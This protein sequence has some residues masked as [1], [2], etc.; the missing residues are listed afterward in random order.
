MARERIALRG[1]AAS[2]GVGVGRAVVITAERLH[3]R[4]S[5]IAAG[6]VNFEIERLRDAIERSRRELEDIRQ[7]LGDEAPADYRLILDA[8]MMM[9][10]DQLLVDMA[11]EAILHELFNAE[12]AVETAVGK[13]G[14]HLQQAPVDYFRDR[15]VDVEHVGRR[16]IAQLTGRVSSLPAGLAESVLGRH[17]RARGRR[18]RADRRCVRWR[19]RARSRSGRV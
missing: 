2:P 7:R 9:H 17:H 5:R 19:G 18:R 12:W 4:H 10:S 3:V 16:I 8:H 1:I 14:H 6:E 11:T 13:I 15:A